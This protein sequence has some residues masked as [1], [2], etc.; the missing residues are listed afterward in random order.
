MYF[1]HKWFQFFCPGCTET[2]VRVILS[3]WSCESLALE[4]KQ[5]KLYIHTKEK[6]IQI[7][8]FKR[9]VSSPGFVTLNIL[10]GKGNSGLKI[11]R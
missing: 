10:G 2:F 7:L 1:K 9:N 3:H 11:H 4:I 8:L 5:M 6:E